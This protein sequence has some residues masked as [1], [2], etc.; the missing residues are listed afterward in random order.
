MTNGLPSSPELK[1]MAKHI[2]HNEHDFNHF[3]ADKPLN[4]VEIDFGQM[5]HDS[6][7]F[8]ERLGGGITA[9]EANLWAK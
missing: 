3:L 2:G 5:L 8:G 9:S 4:I 6:D 7:F 1:V